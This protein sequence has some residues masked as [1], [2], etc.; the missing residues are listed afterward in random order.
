[1]LG[2]WTI[3]GTRYAEEEVH[4]RG[5]NQQTEI[6]GSDHRLWQHCCRSRPTHLGLGANLLPLARRVWWSR[7]GPGLTP[8][9]VG[10]RDQPAQACG[11][12]TYLGQPDTQEG[13]GGNLLSP[14]RRRLY[15][16]HIRSI[17][18]V[19]E[20]RACRVLAQPRSTQRVDTEETIHTGNPQ[21]RRE[22]SRK[23]APAAR[24]LVESKPMAK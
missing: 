15:V 12:R 13:L 11:G 5:N 14:A 24:T 21:L 22:T 2:S 17:F 20:R 9:G 7:S 10:D 19:S 8:E 6:G 23:S 16:Q 18:A 1:M 3:Q 4:S